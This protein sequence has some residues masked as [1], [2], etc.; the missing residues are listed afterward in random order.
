M[1]APND[2][3]LGIVSDEIAADF[4]SG[5]SRATNC[6]ALSADVCRV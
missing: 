3:A 4:P 2:L 1:N 5:A 6:A